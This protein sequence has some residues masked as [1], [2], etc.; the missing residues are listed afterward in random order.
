MNFEC[1]HQVLLG[2]EEII[3]HRNGNKWDNTCS[4]LVR[5]DPVKNARN[6]KVNSRNKSSVTG[7]INRSRGG[8]QA[9]IGN[10]TKMLSFFS[11]DFEEAVAWRLRKEEELGHTIRGGITLS[12]LE[13]DSDNETPVQEIREQESWGLSSTA[14]MKLFKHI[15]EKSK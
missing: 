15:H 1:F 14:M 8:F 10:G 11:W 12:D 13:S 9:S 3:D 2:P 7:V 5:S 6:H 4:N